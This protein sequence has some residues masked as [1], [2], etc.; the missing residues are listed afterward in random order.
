MLRINWAR[1]TGNGS[2]AP[3]PRAGTD[4]RAGACAA[5]TDA[6]TKRAAAPATRSLRVN[7]RRTISL[8]GLGPQPVGRGPDNAERYPFFIVTFSSDSF[9]SMSSAEVAGF[10]AV[11]IA[12]ILPDLS[13]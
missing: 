3:R 2:V 8:A 11:S 4:P 7:M 1:L 13:M 9:A 6:N 5:T 10:T 12:V